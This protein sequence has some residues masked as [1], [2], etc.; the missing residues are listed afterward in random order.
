MQ[1]D[2]ALF[3]LYHAVRHV[4]RPQVVWYGGLWRER[5]KGVDSGLIDLYHEV[6]LL[7]GTPQDV[8]FLQVAAQACLTVSNVV[9]VLSGAQDVGFCAGGSPSGK[10]F[11]V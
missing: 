2:P 1:G 6:R 5:G 10:V 9:G 11:V 3:D 7:R 8:D 4:T